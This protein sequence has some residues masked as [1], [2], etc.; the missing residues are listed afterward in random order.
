[1]CIRDRVSTQSTWVAKLEFHNMLLSKELKNSVVL[2][3]ANKKD[4]PT[5]KSE[6]EIA[7]RFGLH[8]VTDH[9]WNI[10]SCC[11][12]TGEGLSEGL[13]WL[14]GRLLHRA[15]NPAGKAPPKL[16]QGKLSQPSNE[17]EKGAN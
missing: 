10:R 16:P 7:E 15:K 3:L 11:A 17:E 1:M 6:E 14:C 4:L 13:D 9:E 2:V 8:F 12:I 5:A